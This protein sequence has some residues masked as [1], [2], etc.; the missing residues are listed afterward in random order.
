MNQKD[1]TTEGVGMG[2]K[3][4]NTIEVAFD[5]LLTCSLNLGKQI[6]KEDI[7]EGFGN[8]SNEHCYEDALEIIATR[9]RQQVIA[10]LMMGQDLEDGI[11]DDITAIKLTLQDNP[12]VIMLIQ[13]ENSQGEFE[14]DLISSDFEDE[15]IKSVQQPAVIAKMLGYDLESSAQYTTALQQFSKFLFDNLENEF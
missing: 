3:V 12:E 4:D 15:I 11:L 14:I 13:R 8:I 10:T 5:R 7:E 6:T 9:D 2:E 1:K